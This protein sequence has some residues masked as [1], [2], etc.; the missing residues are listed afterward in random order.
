MKE[1][2][3]VSRREFFRFKNS[4]ESQ[5]QPDQELNDVEEFLIQRLE[6][7]H[8]RRGVIKVGAVFA[9]GTIVPNGNEQNRPENQDHQNTNPNS[10]IKSEN[11]QLHESDQQKENRSLETM[12]QA[13]AISAVETAAISAAKFLKLPAERILTQSQTDL[14]TRGHDRAKTAVQLG[15]GPWVTEGIYRYLPNRFFAGESESIRWEFGVP[16]SL[17]YSALTTIDSRP[18]YSKYSETI[19]N[20]NTPPQLNDIINAQKELIVTT[21][22][23]FHYN[24]K[25]PAFTFINSLFLWDKVRRNGYKSAVL[26]RAM[27]DG[28]MFALGRTLNQFKKEQPAG[29]NK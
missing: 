7:S 9:L 28:T 12:A 26:A 20:L 14:M 17:V 25:I 18:D 6:S 22:G 11:S 23:A 10:S 27:M 5:G 3:P 8:T 29:Q 16:V 13:G 21:I 1:S 24:G 15:L 19:R 2:S 4:R